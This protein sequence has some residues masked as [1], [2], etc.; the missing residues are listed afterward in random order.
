MRPA[1]IFTFSSETEA[2]QA[3]FT[4]ALAKE[5][6]SITARHLDE[7]NTHRYSHGHTWRH[8][9]EETG[10]PGH[11]EEHSA[12]MTIRFEDVVLCD[13]NLILAH[14]R[15]ASE[16]FHRQFLQMLYR[17]VSESCDRTGNTISQKDHPNFPQAFLQ[18]LKTVEFGVNRDGEVSIPEMHLDT[19]TFSKVIPELEAQPESFRREVDAVMASKKAEALEREAQRLARFRQAA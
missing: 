6:L 15:A 3:A 4:K 9:T 14:L 8:H 1:G 2:F 17:T 13:D 12:E 11:M 16:A 7:R 19:K 5:V 18:M 10:D